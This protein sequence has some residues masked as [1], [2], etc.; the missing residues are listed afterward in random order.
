MGGT[1]NYSLISTYI[2][3]RVAR[4][5]LADTSAEAIEYTLRH[6][7]RH[8]GDDPRAWTEATV[9]SWVDP[10]RLRPNTRKAMLHRLRPHV[11]WLRDAG[12]MHGDPTAH[13]A[14]IRPPKGGPRDLARDEVHALLRACPDDRAVLIVLLMVHCA[15][16]CS[17]VARIRIEDVD[18][19]RRLINVRAKGGR[20]ERTHWVPVPDEAWTSVVRMIRHLK[21]STG[22]LIESYQVPGTGLRGHSISAL[23]REWI[24]D[25]GLKE[26]PHDGRS[27]H[28]LRHTCAQ[29]MIDGGAD[30]RTVQFGLGH[31]TIRST[32]IYT[33]REPPGLREAMEGR[34]Y[35]SAA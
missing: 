9:V 26:F 3:E 30:L 29:D 11:R 19:R 2:R 7:Y 32:E 4:G 34:A 14:P 17:D 1:M 25:A 24:T 31:S 6:W 21:R 20:G 13:I 15:L 8:A 5:E 33:R 12:H 18:A 28:A 22:P 23:V 16:R 35:L 10:K 27:A